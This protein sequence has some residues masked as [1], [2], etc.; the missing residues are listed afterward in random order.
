MNDNSVTGPCMPNYGT[1]AQDAAE[2]PPYYTDVGTLRKVYQH[3]PYEI[4]GTRNWK[5]TPVRNTECPQCV[6][7]RV[8]RNENE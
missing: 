8:S 5:Y 6:R 1:L 3:K 7:G 4:C 2:E